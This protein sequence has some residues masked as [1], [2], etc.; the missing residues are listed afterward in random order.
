[1]EKFFKLNKWTKIQVVCLILAMLFFTYGKIVASYNVQIVGIMFLWLNN[2]FFC[3]KNF[4]QRVLFFFFNIT[5]YVFLLS[6]PSISLMRGNIWWNWGKEN[7]DFTMYS[8][9]L[10]LLSLFI[11]A[12]AFSQMKLKNFNPKQ[13]E[14]QNAR[15]R[16]ILLLLSGLVYLVS[17]SVTVIINMEK[18]MFVR[19]NTYEAFYASF[20]STFPSYVQAISWMTP[21]AICIFLACMP[22]KGI[23]YLALGMY[24]VSTLPTLLTGQ[25]AAI[26]LN[27]LFALVYF[28][29]RDYLQ[30]SQKWI[31]KFE[32]AM[33]IIGAPVMIITM[34][35]YNYIRAQTY[36]ET[37]GIFSL[38]TDFFFKQGTS[39]DTITFG[40]GMIPQLPFHEIKNYTFGGFIDTLKFGALGR[41]FTD[42][43]LMGSN[44]GLERGMISNSMAHNL[45]YVYRQDK[46]MEGNGN[47]SSYLLELY[48]DYGYLGIII[49]SLLFGILLILLVIILKRNNAFLS[50]LSLVC[51][52]NVFFIP[53]ASATGWLSFILKT[54][55]VVP[56]LACFLGAFILDRL[57]SLKNREERIR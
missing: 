45:A 15:Y 23:S 1:M 36:V 49:A 6:R 9:I 3:F 55:F 17:L 35:A 12:A 19:K 10:T 31:N 11:G 21:F 37:K 2:L 32:K 24:V 56:V 22:K 25:R 40:H 26:I 38:I 47:G 54:S 44:N 53:R 16:K 57:L 28:I 33:I 4:G 50:M 43:P 14:P 42:N 18:L 7:I 34:G 39:F 5:I 30:D 8:L 13:L 52:S 51:I 46:Y 48:A 20:H 41:F 29:L 27:V